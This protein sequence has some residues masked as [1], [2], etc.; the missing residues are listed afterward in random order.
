MIW[1]SFFSVH[2]NTPSQDITLV[3]SKVKGYRKKDTAFFTFFPSFI[4]QI[5]IEYLGNPGYT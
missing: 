3:P 4:Q 5:F 2:Q 1:F